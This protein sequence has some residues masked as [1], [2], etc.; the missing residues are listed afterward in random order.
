LV[1]EKVR[2]LGVLAALGFSPIRRG[3]L[4]LFVGSLGSAVGA[5]LGYLGA[6][7]LVQN[8]IAVEAFLKDEFGIEIFASDI[9]VIDGIPVHWDPA[10]A[11]KLTIAAFLTGVLFTLGPAIRAASLSPIEALRYE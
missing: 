8:H 2:D 10:M 3:S 4:L 5:G 9:Y 7:V 1:R 11:V 6:Y